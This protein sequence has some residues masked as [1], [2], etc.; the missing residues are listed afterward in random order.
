MNTSTET[1]EKPNNLFVY[2]KY[3]FIGTV[4]A[5]IAIILREVVGRALPADSPVYY[6]ISII[7]VYALGILISYVGHRL[8]SFGHVKDL[9]FSKSQ[10]LGAFITV[11]LLGM[12]STMVLALGIRYLLPIDNLLGQYG[13]AF[14]FAL[15]TL[16][17]SVGTFILNGTYTFRVAHRES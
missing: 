9:H 15:A 16:I 14:A 3:A 8:F 6:A 17:T 5:L 7:L 11:A 2:L 13:A 1:P 10:S 12:V 4:V